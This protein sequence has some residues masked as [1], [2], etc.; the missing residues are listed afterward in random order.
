MRRQFGLES[1]TAFTILLL[2]FV[3][4]HVTAQQ[5]GGPAEIDPATEPTTI[6]ARSLEVDYEQN[7]ARFVG[8]VV[9][10]DP[11]LRLTADR[12]TVIFDPASNRISRIDAEGRV[13]RS[14]RVVKIK[15]RSG[16]ER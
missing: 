14:G 12:L 8:D 7:I 6:D 3:P 13:E 16:D 5:N 10:V 4:L 11:Q 2:C 1:S 15:A 9:V